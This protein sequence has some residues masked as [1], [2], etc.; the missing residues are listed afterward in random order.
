MLITVGLAACGAPADEVAGPSTASAPPATAPT[1]A[2]PPAPTTAPAG[3]VPTP[4][5]T[6]GAPVTSL[7]PC[8]DVPDLVTPVI[9]NDPTGLGPD[10]VFMGVLQTYASEHP[11][12]FAGLWLDRE[13]GGTVV[14]AFT[15]DPVAHREALAARRPSP[16]DTQP[17]EPP[18]PITDDR[19]IGEWDVAFDVVRT[20]YTE[21]ELQNA[22]TAALQALADSGRT[23]FGVGAALTRNR[24]SLFP[25]GPIT[26]DDAA[27]LAEVIGAVTSL[28][29]I[30]LDGAI[31]DSP[32]ATIAPGTPLEVI[33]LP[34][35]D[36]AYPPSTAVECGGVAFTLGDLQARAPVEE[37]DPGLLAV[38]TEWLA[39][40]MGEVLPD[41]GWFVLAQ[42]DLTATLANVVDGGLSVIGAEMG[43]NGW[44]WAGSGGGGACVVR[45]LPPA[46]T[47]AVDWALDPAFPTPDAGSTE[48]HVLATERACT[49]GSEIGDRLLGPQVVETDDA[50]RIAFAS[51]PLTGS[52]TCPGNPS[53]AVTIALAAALGE[54]AILDGL[55]IAPLTDLIAD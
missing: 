25:P 11:D 40:P 14:L 37:A 45:R 44:I 43:R 16:D 2:S 4:V 51:I 49:G 19:P 47:G 6:T 18:V 26:T 17:V 13:A 55:A 10:P 48:L 3:P 33:V 5:P 28:G 50:V 29:M 20:T 39:S 52:Q 23:E 42:D 12:T 35:A 21:V 1:T 27:T 22:S 9:G 24:V 30:C 41:E 54:R 38:V 34:G 15:D 8:T 36:G 31:V 53:T 32:P 46:G 7:Q